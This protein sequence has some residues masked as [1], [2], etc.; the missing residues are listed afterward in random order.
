MEQEEHRRP[1]SI[2][3]VG[4]L[5]FQVRTLLQKWAFFLIFKLLVGVQG[6]ADTVINVVEEEVGF[7]ASVAAEEGLFHVSY[8]EA[9]IAWAYAV[10]MA[11][12]LVCRKWKE[13]KEKLL[14]IRTSS[15]K[16][17][18]VSG[19]FLKKDPDPKCQLSCFSDAACPAVFLQH[20]AVLYLLGS[21]VVCTYHD[22]HVHRSLKVAT[23]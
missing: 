8:E 4:K 5:T 19:P 7:R 6:S 17:M 18:R 22:V 9:G 20:H 21:P 16:R 15:V 12:P 10:S 2:K 11:T 3:G 23:Q 1:S 14:R 13:L